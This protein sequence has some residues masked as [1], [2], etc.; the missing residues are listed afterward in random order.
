MENS[1]YKNKNETHECFVE[2]LLKYQYANNSIYKSKQIKNCSTSNNSQN[3]SKILS[4]IEESPGFK[5]SPQTVYDYCNNRRIIREIL[6][7]W[8]QRTQD[9]IPKDFLAHYFSELCQSNAKEEILA[10]LLKHPNIDVMAAGTYKIKSVK[11]CH[12]KK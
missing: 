10:E 5:P 7:Y 4:S 1:N 12:F 11:F 8:Q 2:E 9:I 3:L 6:N